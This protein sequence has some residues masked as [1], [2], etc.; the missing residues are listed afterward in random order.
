MNPNT[1][2]ILFLKDLFL[3][4]RPLFT[5][6]VIGLVA[7]A[8]ACQ[9]QATIAYVGFILVITVAIGA[10]FH[11]I[12]TLL[13][14]ETM[15]QTRLFVMSLPIS[16]LDYSIGKIAVILTTYL[17]P[18]TA[19]FVILTIAAY[20]MG[21]QGNVAILPT[22]FLFLLGSFTLQLVAAVI[23]NSVGWTI[24]VTVACNI[25]LNV[26]I[27]KLFADPEV[28]A[29]SKSNVL[30]WPNSVLQI[31]AVELLIIGLALVLA[32]LF[33]TRQRDLV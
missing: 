4:R 3:S 10:G 26:F 13:L 15:T 21:Q 30:S 17:I 11:L 9:P 33:Q 28:S 22:I 27:V 29:L 20:V 16:L 31:I 8:L 18:W 23:S 1:I 32:F 24:G 5:Y 14:A 6:F 7:S 2:R 19:M 12:G 25:C